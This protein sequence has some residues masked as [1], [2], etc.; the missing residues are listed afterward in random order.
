VATLV[1]TSEPHAVLDLLGASLAS[2]VQ[3]PRA[4]GLLLVQITNYDRVTAVFGPRAAHELAVAVA[5]R[6]QRVAKP[7]D[8][9]ARVTDAKFVVVVDPARTQGV[10]V[11][12]ANRVVESLGAPIRVGDANVNALPKVGIALAPAPADASLWLQHA[13]AALL[14]AAADA[15]AYA[16]FT[17]ALGGRAADSL[18]LELELDNAIKRNELEVYYQPKVSAAT[19]EPCGAEALLRWTSATRGRVS[20]DVFIPLADQ[21]G[22]IEPLTAF[23]LNTALRQSRAWPAR[24]EPLAV[25]VN[26]TPRVIEGG[27]LNGLVGSAL[28]LW[29]AAPQRLFVEITEGAIMRN[30][31]ASFAVLRELREQGVRISIDD[32]GTGYSSLAYFKNIPADEL[33]IDKSFVMKMLHDDGDRK[34]VRAIVELAKSF[35]LKVTAEGV[36]DAA[37][38]LALAELGC[39]T[40]QGYHYS[41]PLPNGKFVAWLEDYRVEGRDRRHG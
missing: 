17:P 24:W 30:P 27:E 10:L 40:L 23:V 19:L 4:L 41:P 35:G 6:L 11:L 7:T 18:G 29:D 25:A 22:L 33:K 36:E 8:R 3:E 15:V 9:I 31:Q 34:I 39:D 2:R 38:A 20:P 14:S 13:E 28:S 37:T 16:F 5:E 1:P 32:F 26:V 21:P 12:A